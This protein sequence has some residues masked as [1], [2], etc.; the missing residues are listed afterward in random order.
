MK[1]ART[2]KSGKPADGERRTKA[3]C[4]AGACVLLALFFATI[5]AIDVPKEMPAQPKPFVEIIDHSGDAAIG[6]DE[7]FD[8][9][10]L[11]I[12]TRWNA[13]APES[14]LPTPASWRLA[15][16]GSDAL[17]GEVL[18]SG[19]MR[20]GQNAIERARTGLLHSIM[21][22]VFSGFGRE[23][24]NYKTPENADSGTL[25]V[26]DTRTGN[27]VYTGSIPKEVAGK[28]ISIAE[29]F[30]D[31]EDDGWALRPLIRETSGNENTDEELSK[32]LRSGVLRKLPRGKYKAV[33][34][35]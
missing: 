33:F 17:G 8:D 7:I 1:K 23:N 15:P 10:P 14:K 29:F 2:D 26:I 25:E 3:A 31:I 9:S 6:M 13:S 24:I 27:K 22:H 28:M 11:F 5:P 20:G 32:I 18:S 34:A 16:P 12:P 30:V 35:P 21:R 19:F 4:I